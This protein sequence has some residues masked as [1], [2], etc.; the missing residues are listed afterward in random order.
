[1]ISALSVWKFLHI[2][3]FVYWLGA[4]LGVF[5]LALA[6]RRADLSYEARTLALQMAVVIDNTPRIAFALMFPVGL[7]L[8]VQIGAI[9]APATW[10]H[11]LVWLVS[12]FWVTTVL[13]QMRGEGTA[14]GQRMHG[15]GLALKWV[16]LVV[17]CAVGLASVTGHGPFPAGWLA[18]KVLLFGAIF[19]CGILIDR[20]FGP[21]VPAFARLKA[22]GSTPEI[23]QAISAAVYGAIRWVLALYG[24]VLAIAFIGT[25]KP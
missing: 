22:E 16:L 10:L 20:D 17:V 8:S 4:D 19:A 7:E 3:L 14:F 11:A 12:A 5:L 2:L 15:A 23:E 21:I 9:E 18:W 24:L 13:A 1:M 25:V 6:A